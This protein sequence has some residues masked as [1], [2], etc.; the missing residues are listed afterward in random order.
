LRPPQRTLAG[1]PPK[2]SLVICTLPEARGSLLRDCNHLWRR[3]PHRDTGPYKGPICR[4]DM[5]DF[6]LKASP[7]RARERSP[8]T[9]VR[10]REILRTSQA[11]SSRNLGCV[12]PRSFDRSIEVK[13]CGGVYF[14]DPSRVFSLA[15][16]VLPIVLGA[17]LCLAPL[18]CRYAWRTSSGA[19][20]PSGSG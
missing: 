12:T 19:P 15:A 7:L 18:R 9:Q 1:I 8:F 4:Y 5:L 11:R 10:G 6:L 13:L 20:G 2:R 14:A 16:P 3:A 17:A